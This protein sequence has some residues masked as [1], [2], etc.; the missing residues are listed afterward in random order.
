VEIHSFILSKVKRN[1]TRTRRMQLPHLKVD[2]HAFEASRPSFCG[3]PFFRWFDGDY[4]L[5][6]DEPVAVV[7]SL[8]VQ[9]ENVAVDVSGSAIAGLMVSEGI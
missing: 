9:W 4:E 5:V 2:M 7:M 6:I 1:S 8:S 3:I